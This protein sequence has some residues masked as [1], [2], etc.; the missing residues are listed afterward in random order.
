VSAFDP[1]RTLA[2]KRMVLKSGISE[3]AIKAV[4]RAFHARQ[5]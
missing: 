2:R 5:V 3:F 1:K 4:M